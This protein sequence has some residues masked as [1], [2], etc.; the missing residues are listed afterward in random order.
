MQLLKSLLTFHEIP[1]WK[2]S[3]RLDRSQAYVSNLLK[4]ITLPTRAEAEAIK[5][6]VHATSVDDIFPNIR[7]DPR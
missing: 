3:Q 7:E 1:Q 5:K 4:G 6:L 2:L